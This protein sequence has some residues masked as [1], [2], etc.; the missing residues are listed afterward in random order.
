MHHHF[1]K[2]R[3]VPYSPVLHLESPTG[4]EKAYQNLGEFILGNFTKI[5]I[6]NH[7]SN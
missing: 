5:S 4:S 6:H 1:P 7:S 3:S 2:L